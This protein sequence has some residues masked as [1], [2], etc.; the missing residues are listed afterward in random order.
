MT[1]HRWTSPV[2]PGT[3]PSVNDIP[4]S[5]RDPRYRRVR[6]AWMRDMAYAFRESGNV[7]PRRL[8]WARGHAVLQFTV[9]RRRDSGNYRCHLEKML[10]DALQITGRLRDDTHDLYEF[11]SVTF[12]ID[13][14]AREGHF[15]HIEYRLEGEQ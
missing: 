1:V 14:K 10:G 9:E 7:L 12:L 11:G 4:L 3:P 13:P 5:S 2:L 8:A 15:L 6:K